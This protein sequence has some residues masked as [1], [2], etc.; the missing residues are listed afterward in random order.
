MKIAEELLVLFKH[1]N[2]K[3]DNKGI[4][5]LEKITNTIRRTYVEINNSFKELNDV[6]EKEEKQ[7]IED[8]A[9]DKCIIEELEAKVSEMEEKLLQVRK[10]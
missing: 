10:G 4:E 6:I 3:G 2:K 9:K 1:L 7:I 8:K 5:M